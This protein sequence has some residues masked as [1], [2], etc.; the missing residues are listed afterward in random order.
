MPWTV[1]K[2]GDE[3]CVVKQDTGLP[4]PGGCHKSKQDAIKHL[5]AIKVNTK[6]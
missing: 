3:Y 1:K 6:E 2:R 4:V 5:V